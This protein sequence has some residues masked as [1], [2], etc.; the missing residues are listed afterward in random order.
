[1]TGDAI[2]GYP[3]SS[4]ALLTPLSFSQSL[5]KFGLQ[6]NHSGDIQLVLLLSSGTNDIFMTSPW[7]SFAINC[8]LFKFIFNTTSSA[9]AM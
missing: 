2:D 8:L 7:N 6:E 1:M 4:F 3:S 5:R 9:I